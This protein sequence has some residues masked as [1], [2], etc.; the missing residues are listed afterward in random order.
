MGRPFAERES[1]KVSKYD[2]R[3]L[4]GFIDQNALIPGIK[5]AHFAKK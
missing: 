1:M 5:P 2:S 3:S 4:D